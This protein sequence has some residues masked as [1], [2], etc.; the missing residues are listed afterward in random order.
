MFLGLIFILFYL[1]N[2]YDM[3]T[4]NYQVGQNCNDFNEKLMNLNLKEIQISSN[5]D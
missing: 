3:L 1:T 2:H 5:L 4:N